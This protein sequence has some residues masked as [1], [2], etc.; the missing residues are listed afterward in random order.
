MAWLLRLDTA[1]PYRLKTS[2]K[3]QCVCHDSSICQH[4]RLD[5]CCWLSQNV[6]VR[7]SNSSSPKTET[8]LLS[9]PELEQIITWETNN[10]YDYLKDLYDRQHADLADY[11]R[12]AAWLFRTAA[13]IVQ[14]DCPT[15]V[16][17]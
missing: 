5:M 8:G 9:R 14:A 3:H 13:C 2:T 11:N 1:W 10:L 4:A 17:Y 12:S 7:Y 15:S 6:Q 16:T